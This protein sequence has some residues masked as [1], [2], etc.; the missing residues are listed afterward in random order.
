MCVGV[1]PRNTRMMCGF[2]YLPT[3][4]SPNF[5]DFL[6]L[7]GNTID[8]EYQACTTLKLNAK[9]ILPFDLH[10]LPVINVFPFS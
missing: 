4:D 6:L 8:D 5:S 3:V 10:I 1:I 7:V 9:V 2:V